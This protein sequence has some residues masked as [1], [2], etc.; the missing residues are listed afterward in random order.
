VLKD[1][2]WPQFCPRPFA[3]WARENGATPVESISVVQAV[4]AGPEKWTLLHFSRN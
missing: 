4:S 3:E 2:T 1:S